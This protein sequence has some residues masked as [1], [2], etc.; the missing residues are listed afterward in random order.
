MVGLEW[1]D[2]NANTNTNTNTNRRMQRM[3][4]DGDVSE[5]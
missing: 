2:V 4:V 5:R 3:L 1:E